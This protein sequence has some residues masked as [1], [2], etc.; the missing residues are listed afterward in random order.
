MKMRRTKNDWRK[1]QWQGEKQCEGKANVNKSKQLHTGYE[2]IQ[3]V[4]N[5][6]GV[7]W[8]QKNFPAETPPEKQE[9]FQGKTLQWTEVLQM[10]TEM[11]LVQ[12]TE[13]LIWC[14][15]PPKQGNGFGYPS[16]PFD[17][18]GHIT[19]I[20]QIACSFVTWVFYQTNDFGLQI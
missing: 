5:A 4:K 12:V 10:G 19:A 9:T 11:V 16:D 18:Y 7:T 6:L 3:T 1:K 14:T 20:K 13:E 8:R 17:S 2:E 15:H